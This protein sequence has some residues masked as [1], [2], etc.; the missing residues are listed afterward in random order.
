MAKNLAVHSSKLRPKQL[1]K[2][3]TSTT[4][5]GPS[6]RM[7]TPKSKAHTAH[8][9]EPTSSVEEDVAQIKVPLHK[10]CL[11]GVETGAKA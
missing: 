11:Y 6:H 7:V 1:K 8:D 3:Q 5:Q 2:A 9:G 10:A 4:S